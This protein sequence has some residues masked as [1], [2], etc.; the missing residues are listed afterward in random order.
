MHHS[1]MKESLPF[2]SEGS[3]LNPSDW[4]SRKTKKLVHGTPNGN[5]AQS[6]E[7]KIFRE[8]GIAAQQI[9]RPEISPG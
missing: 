4:R 2:G 7:W 8:F 5:A 9:F 3:R 1:T 6:S